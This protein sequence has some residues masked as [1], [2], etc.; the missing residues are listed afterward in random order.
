MIHETWTQLHD[1]PHTKRAHFLIHIIFDSFLH[2]NRCL[3]TGDIPVWVCS[4]FTYDVS[5][6]LFNCPY[7]SCCDDVSTSSHWVWLISNS[8]IHQF[9][10]SS[11]KVA[12][13]YCGVCPAGIGGKIGVKF[14]GV[15]LIFDFSIISLGQNFIYISFF[16][17]WI[18]LGVLGVVI[19]ITIL[20]VLFMMRKRLF[21]QF[22]EFETVNWES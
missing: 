9:S 4:I 7:P 8:S 2:G 15:F 1:H 16:S 10:L 18:V 12:D 13:G 5:D 3:T 6:N 17:G 11:Q 22:Y 19:V 20:I 21:P 14:K